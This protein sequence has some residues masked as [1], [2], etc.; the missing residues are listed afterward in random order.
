MK[1]LVES[2]RGVSG[3][4]LASRVSQAGALKEIAPRLFPIRTQ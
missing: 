1:T 2:G 3:Q 4:P